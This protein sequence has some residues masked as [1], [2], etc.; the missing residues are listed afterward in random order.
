MSFRVVVG[1]SNGKCQQCQWNVGGGTL[2]AAVTVP[3]S[4]HHP[5]GLISIIVKV[6]TIRH[7][8]NKWEPVGPT[9]Q[10]HRCTNNVVAR[11]TAAGRQIPTVVN[12]GWG[13]EVSEYTHTQQ[14]YRWV[15]TGNRR[16]GNNTHNGSHRASMSPATMAMSS[17]RHASSTGEQYRSIQEGCH[18]TANNITHNTTAA[19]SHTHTHVIKFALP[20]HQYPPHWFISHHVTTS[21]S[22]HRHQQ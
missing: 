21:S 19:G 5:P 7:Q 15:N 4:L 22:S 17:C 12:W 8:Q 9:A 3:L 13:W 11:H 1:N 2:T 18:V 6:T 16:W 14:Q 10:C 20:S